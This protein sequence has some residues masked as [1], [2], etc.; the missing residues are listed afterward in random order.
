MFWAD[1]VRWPMLL[2]IVSGVFAVLYRWAPNRGQVWWST[3]A[4]GS[5]FAAVL[6]VCASFLFSWYI[7][8]FGAL[9]DIYG[10]LSAMIAFMVWIWLSVISLLAGAGLDA[11]LDTHRKDSLKSSGKEG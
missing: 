10:P 8:R 5:S 7:S 6:W 9:T 11:L 3:V 4:G 1:V 2:I